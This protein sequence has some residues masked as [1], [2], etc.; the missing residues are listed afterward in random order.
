MT[1]LTSPG[2]LPASVTSAAGN[3]VWAT[4]DVSGKAGAADGPNALDG[5]VREFT[6][7]GS[8]VVYQVDCPA[9]PTPLIATAQREFPVGE[10]V[11][12]LQVV[13]GE[14]GGASGRLQ[15]PDLV[16]EAP[17]AV[18][19]QPRGRLVEEHQFGVAGERQREHHPLFLPSGELSEAPVAEFLEPRHFE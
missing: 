15:P 12:L 3:S 18:E 9:L 5:T 11:R 1:K 16:P 10:R 6:Y 19:V 13:R 17:T 2:W 4:L 7:I 8:A 14:D